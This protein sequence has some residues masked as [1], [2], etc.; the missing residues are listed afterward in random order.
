M[1]WEGL[2]I[3]LLVAHLVGDFVLQTEW[4]ATNKYAGLG[5]DPLARRALGLHVATYMCAFIPGLIALA[6]SFGAGAAL[7]VAI[8]IAGTHAVQDDGRLLN[9]HMRAIK[10]SE[11][12]PGPL[13]IACDQS[14][15]I[16]VL[17]GIALLV[18]G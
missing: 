11:P 7:L 17:F 8:V 13:L 6:G 4:Q 9:A 15:H 5:P 12:R 2:F 16:V 14:F 3:V 18:A 1:T 10:H